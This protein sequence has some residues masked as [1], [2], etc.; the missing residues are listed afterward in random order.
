MPKVDG[1][2]EA[3]P[4]VSK[5]E[6]SVSREAIAPGMNVG[7]EGAALAREGSSIPV[8]RVL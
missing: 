1:R 3:K 2:E 4:E 8:S 7:A 5:G 6:W